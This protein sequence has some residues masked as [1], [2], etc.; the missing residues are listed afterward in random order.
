MILSDEMLKKLI[1][2]LQ[3]GAECLED[4]A[5]EKG[6]WAWEEVVAGLLEMKSEIEEMQSGH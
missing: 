2:T 4:V 1:E 3:E 6:G 5:T